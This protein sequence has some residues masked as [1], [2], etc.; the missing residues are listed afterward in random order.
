MTPSSPTQGSAPYRYRRVHPV[1]PQEHW[2]QEL[3]DRAAEM[4]KMA[5]AEAGHP[6]EPW[7]LGGVWYAPPGTPEWLLDKGRI[8]VFEALGIEY[9]VDGVES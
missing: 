2:P 4:L 3:A 5:M 8:L 1:V 7:E 6:V 9:R